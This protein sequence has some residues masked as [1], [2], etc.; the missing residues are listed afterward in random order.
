M[1]GF[2]WFKQDAVSNLLLLLKIDPAKATPEQRAQAER[3]ID[4]TMRYTRSLTGH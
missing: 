3:V 4:S 2:N 1:S